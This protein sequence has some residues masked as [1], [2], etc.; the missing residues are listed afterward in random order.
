MMII[1]LGGKVRQAASAKGEAHV[2]ERSQTKREQYAILILGL[3]ISGEG[4]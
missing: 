3:F 4:K 1:A 2:T